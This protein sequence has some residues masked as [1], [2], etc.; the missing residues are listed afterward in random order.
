M[1]LQLGPR[2]LAVAVAWQPT[3]QHPL[4]GGVLAVNVCRTSD[5]APSARKVYNLILQGFLADAGLRTTFADE[6]LL[7]VHPDLELP[8]PAAARTAPRAARPTPAVVVKPAPTAADRLVPPHKVATHLIAPG[9][10][11]TGAGR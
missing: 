5:G 1:V 6:H 4:P 10:A 11:A 7:V 8:A 2:G 3:E 9:A